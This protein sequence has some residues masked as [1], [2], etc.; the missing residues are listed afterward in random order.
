MIPADRWF[1]VTPSTRR[2]P[3]TPLMSTGWSGPTGFVWAMSEPAGV[4]SVMGPISPATVNSSG[5][6]CGAVPMVRY[7][8][9]VGC[10]S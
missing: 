5:S 7:M 9:W 6:K 10:N 4:G 3:A 8:C 2:V 1:S